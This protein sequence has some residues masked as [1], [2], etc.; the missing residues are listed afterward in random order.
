MSFIVGRSV[1]LWHCLYALIVMSTPNVKGQQVYS[2]GWTELFGN[3]NQFGETRS[4]GEEPD[5]DSRASSLPS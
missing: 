4:A 3:L 5:S 1:V 2:L